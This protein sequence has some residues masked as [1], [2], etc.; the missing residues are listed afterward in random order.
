MTLYSIIV[1]ADTRVSF[2]QFGWIEHILLVTLFYEKYFGSYSHKNET[3]KFYYRTNFTLLL[4]FYVNLY[5]LHF[6]DMNTPFKIIYWNVKHPFPSV[7]KLIFETAM[8]RNV[9]TNK[10]MIINST[11][12]TSQGPTTKQTLSKSFI[13][14][15][16]FTKDVCRDA[17]CSPMSKSS[18]TTD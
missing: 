18:I 9:M 6:V 4:R 16:N 14:V 15:R 5:L 8:L 17:V 2:R 1:F 12:Y 11:Y 10:N 13:Y 3:F 7:P